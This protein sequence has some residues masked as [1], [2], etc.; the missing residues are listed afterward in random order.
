MF[1]ER[2]LETLERKLPSSQW[3]IDYRAQSQAARTLV[4][5]NKA[6]ENRGNELVNKSLM[7][8]VKKS[9]IHT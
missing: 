6:R 9:W 2:L 3:H 1:L 5:G 7:F 4:S 8:A